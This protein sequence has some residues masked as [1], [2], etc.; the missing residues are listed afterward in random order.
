MSSMG[1]LKFFL[2]LQVQ[3]RVDGIYIHQDQYL[4]DTLKKFDQILKLLY[5]VSFNSIRD[6]EAIAQR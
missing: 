3:Q 2:G 5:Q 4:E 1:E 6:K